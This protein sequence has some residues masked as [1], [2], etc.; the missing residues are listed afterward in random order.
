MSD[1][2]KKQTYVVY[3]YD[4]TGS[5]NPVSV[6]RSFL[7]YIMTKNGKIHSK[8]IEVSNTSN[9]FRVADLEG[10]TGKF[11]CLN[12]NMPNVLINKLLPGITSSLLWSN[13]GLYIHYYWLS[14]FC[15]QLLK[16]PSVHQSVRMYLCL[17]CVTVFDRVSSGCLFII[18]M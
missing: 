11:V 14:L 9:P 2:N 13:V 6:R 3:L 17:F 18:K 1:R 8:T 16:L 12:K 5:D 4:P 7:G 10:N 15:L